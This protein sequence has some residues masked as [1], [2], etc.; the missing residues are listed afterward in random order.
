M[1]DAGRY[2]QGLQPG[3][4]APASS[5]LRET[6]QQA[7]QKERLVNAAQLSPHTSLRL[8]LDR[9]IVFLRV[10]VS[11]SV[12]PAPSTFAQSA[13]HCSELGCFVFLEKQVFCLRIP[14]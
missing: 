2:T 6:T 9:H 5:H 11:S 1:K 8:L 13:L 3:Q 10:C 7:E 14:A 4:A 12:P